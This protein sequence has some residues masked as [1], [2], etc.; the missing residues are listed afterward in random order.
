MYNF[1]RESLKRRNRDWSILDTHSP[2]HRT[3]LEALL[4]ADQAI[5]LEDEITTLKE[6]AICKSI[7]A[8]LED[9]ED[10]NI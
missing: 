4:Y 2:L 8:K 5:L 6:I 10:T 3:F 1:I 9:N 7:I